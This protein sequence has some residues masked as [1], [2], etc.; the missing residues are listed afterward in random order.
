MSSSVG[1]RQRERQKLERAQD[2][3]QRKAVRQAASADD[4]DA[5]SMSNRS[6][7]ELTDELRALQLAFE[8][9]EVSAEDFDDRRGRLQTQFD[10]LSP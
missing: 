3:A 10:R 7:Q 1:K 2:K 4:A 6:E 9:G 8:D 5:D